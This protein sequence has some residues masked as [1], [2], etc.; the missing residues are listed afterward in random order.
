MNLI[1]VVVRAFSVPLAIL[2]S[3][4]AQR[5]LI[6]II[7]LNISLQVQKHFLLR[8]DLAELGAL[9]GLQVSL[10]TIALAGL[11]GAWLIRRGNRSESRDR[12][13]HTLS[14]VLHRFSAGCR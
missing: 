14:V 2:A 4:K 6:A 8:E 5:V 11:Y 7:A 1:S 13:C 3:G 10:T 9:G 12:V